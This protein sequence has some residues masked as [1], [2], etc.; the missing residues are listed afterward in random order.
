MRTLLVLAALSPLLLVGN[1]SPVHAN[2]TKVHRKVYPLN[3]SW[4]AHYDKMKNVQSDAAVANSEH[5]GLIN[6]DSPGVPRWAGDTQLT[7]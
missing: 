5:T 7:N 2:Q 1:Y 3:P 6:G 4:T